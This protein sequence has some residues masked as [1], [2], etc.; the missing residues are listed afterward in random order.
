M[1]LIDEIT[2]ELTNLSQTGNKMYVGDLQAVK[3]DK[4]IDPSKLGIFAAAVAAS[5]TSSDLE[6][7]TDVAIFFMPFAMQVFEIVVGVGTTPVGS[8]LIVDTN[9]NGVSIGTTTV[10]ASSNT[11]SNTSVDES[12]AKN[13]KVTIDIDQ[14][15]ATTAGQALTVY[16]KGYLL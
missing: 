6:V 12:F 15:G 11:G 13:D 5:D 4:Y 10:S 2:T 8:S 3:T 14:V 7:S 9:K 16:L 1:S